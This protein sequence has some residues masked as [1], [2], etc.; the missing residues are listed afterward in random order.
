MN[1]ELTIISDDLR[2]E[3][4]NKFT[5]AGIY[6]EAIVF[7]QLPSRILK[8][9]FYQRWLDISNLRKVRV[10]LRG[11]AMG[12]TVLRAEARPTEQQP[13]KPHPVRI[14]IFFGPL[15]FLKEG[16][17]EFHTFF[18]DDTKPHWVHQLGVKVDPNIRTQP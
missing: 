16:A 11:S 2:H 18:S 13:D 14:Y 10:E 15:D 6:E 12:E 9:A 7:P 17:I 5:L 8:L 1:H 3:L 4:G